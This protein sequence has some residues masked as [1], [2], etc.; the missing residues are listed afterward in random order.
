MNIFL[1]GFWGRARPGDI[2]QLGGKEGFTPWYQISESCDS[3]CS[4]VSGDA[5]V[6][7]FIAIFYYITKN[8]KFF[9]LSIFLGLFFGF[10]RIG[11]GAH[12][13]SDVLMSFILVNFGL[14]ISRHIYYQIIKWIK[15]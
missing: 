10:A 3:N 1:K 14:L 8:I 5:S 2:L 9:Y 11:A 4:F 12:F 7:F 13:L 6:G 15:V